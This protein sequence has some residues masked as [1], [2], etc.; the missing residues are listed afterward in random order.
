MNYSKVQHRALDMAR[1]FPN[2]RF[3]GTDIGAKLNLSLFT[4][5]KYL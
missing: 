5:H 2:V 4:V 1:E 3:D